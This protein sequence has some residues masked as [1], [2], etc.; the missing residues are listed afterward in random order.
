V[1][2]GVQ[3]A[4]EQVTKRVPGGALGEQVGGDLLQQRLEREIIVSVDD[5]HVDVRLAQLPRGTDPR[6]P[7]AQDKDAR[8]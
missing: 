6:E 2:P 3:L 7:P 8:T 4:V 5:D 1:D